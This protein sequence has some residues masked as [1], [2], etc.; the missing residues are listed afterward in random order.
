MVEYQADHSASH[1]ISS[2]VA[3]SVEANGRIT[4]KQSDFRNPEVRFNALPMQEMH[5]KSESNETNWGRR[6]LYFQMECP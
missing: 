1:H 2:P 5:A 6:V 4:Q 3:S